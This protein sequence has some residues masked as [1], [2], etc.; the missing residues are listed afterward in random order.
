MKQG[1]SALLDDKP[2]KKSGFVKTKKITEGKRINITLTEEELE[3]LREL[4]QMVGIEDISWAN[5]VRTAC[6][7]SPKSRGVKGIGEEVCN[8]IQRGK[9]TS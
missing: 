8:S 3:P 4:K 6:R 1:L 9:P 5:L 7:V 2:M